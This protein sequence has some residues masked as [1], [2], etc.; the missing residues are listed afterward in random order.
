MSTSA[1][2]LLAKVRTTRIP[3]SY[4]CTAGAKLVIDLLIL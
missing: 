1:K 4:V 3:L 2:D